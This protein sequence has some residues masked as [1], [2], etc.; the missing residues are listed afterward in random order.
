M[1]T[2][3]IAERIAA[4]DK[5]IENAMKFQSMSVNGETT[6][7]QNVLSLMRARRELLQEQERLNG[8]RKTCLSFDLS[9]QNY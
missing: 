5:A 7:N 6:T 4:I 3:S 2:S 1:S 8:T 9:E